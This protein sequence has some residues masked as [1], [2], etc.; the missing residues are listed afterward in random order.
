MLCGVWLRFDGA[1]SPRPPRRRPRYRAGELVAWYN[2]R[3]AAGVPA[4]HVSEVVI[5]SDT[6]VKKLPLR[7]HTFSGGCPGIQHRGSIFAIY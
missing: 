5:F 6:W 4:E 1:R 7:R 3:G 2:Q